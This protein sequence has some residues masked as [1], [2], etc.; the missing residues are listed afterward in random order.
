[1]GLC[2]QGSEDKGATW[3][4]TVPSL[5]QEEI[6]T[7]ANPGFPYDPQPRRVPKCVHILLLKAWGALPDPAVGLI[8]TSLPPSPLAL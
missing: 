6:Q 8:S 5:A 2:F 7:Q 3:S 4:P 1:M